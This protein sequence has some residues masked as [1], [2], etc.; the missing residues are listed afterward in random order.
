MALA[1]TPF[2]YDDIAFGCSVVKPPTEMAHTL[3][4]VT[5]QVFVHK[6]NGASERVALDGREREPVDPVS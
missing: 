6:L 5:E 2:L 4:A 3:K 1:I